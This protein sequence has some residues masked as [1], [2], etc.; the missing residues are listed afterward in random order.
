MFMFNVPEVFML[1]EFE[2]IWSMIEEPLHVIL[3]LVVIS[4]FKLWFVIR[5]LIF[6]IDGDFAVVKSIL[7]SPT[8]NNSLCEGS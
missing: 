7:K 5:F 2:Y 1:L 3:V 8:I 6:C 4:G